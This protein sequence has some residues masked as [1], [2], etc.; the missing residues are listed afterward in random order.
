MKLFFMQ[1]QRSPLTEY[2]FWPNGDAWEKLKE[3]LDGKP[4][5]KEA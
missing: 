5:I 1:G 4:W 2:Y 3:S